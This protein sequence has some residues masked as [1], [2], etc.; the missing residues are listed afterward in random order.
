MASRK[1]KPSKKPRSKWT[2]PQIKILVESIEAELFELLKRDDLAALHNE[3]LA[4][5]LKRLKKGA[6]KL[7][8]HVG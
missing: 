6:H 8:L 5:G 1:K 3:E 4:K 7:A 2:R